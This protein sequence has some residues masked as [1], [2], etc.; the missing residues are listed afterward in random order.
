MELS[1]SQHDT[2]NR[3]GPTE[4]KKLPNI[5]TSK[6]QV[7]ALKNPPTPSPICRLLTDAAGEEGRMD[8]GTREEEAELLLTRLERMKKRKKK[9]SFEMF[10]HWSL[11][12]EKR[13]KDL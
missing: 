3:G 12:E 11:D 8:G 1:L 5:F 7:I 4:L 9:F 13:G 6:K 10:P 2:Q